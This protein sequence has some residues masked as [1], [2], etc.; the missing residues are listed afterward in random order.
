MPSRFFKGVKIARDVV[1]AVVPYVVAAAVIGHGLDNIDKRQNQK[2]Q[3]KDVVDTN[4]P[5]KSK[6]A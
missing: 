4:Q 3:A 5:R 2:K 1:E 6:N